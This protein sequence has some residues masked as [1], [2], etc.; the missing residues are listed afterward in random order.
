MFKTFSE[1]GLNIHCTN[2]QEAEFLYKKI[3][4]EQ[5][6]GNVVYPPGGTIVDCGG[7][8][9]MFSLYAGQKTSSIA[10]ARITVFEPISELAKCIEWN[11]RDHLPN[12]MCKIMPLAVSDRSGEEVTLDYLPM[13]TL[14]SGQAARENKDVYANA[15][16]L[17]IPS[18]DQIEDAF[19]AEERKARTITLA[20]ALPCEEYGTI[21]VLKIDVEGME[22]AV[23]NGMTDELL[24][25]VRQIIIEVH[26]VENR[27]EEIRDRLVSA[28]FT[29]EAGP[30]APPCFLLGEGAH[31]KKGLS[32]C[33]LTAFR[34][35]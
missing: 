9:G 6:Y 22:H 5:E 25:R 31:P 17:G 33:N 11:M 19:L 4:V 20:D 28:G 21:D 26:D 24:S 27:I 15:F 35:T 16:G 23:V 34:N 1:G 32:T 8:I 29:V 10:T 2:E 18:Q 12:H 3:F 30:L 13:Y 7:N 14:L